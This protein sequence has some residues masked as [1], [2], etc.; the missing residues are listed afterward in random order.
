MSGLLTKVP[1][2][3]HPAPDGLLKEVAPLAQQN[4]TITHK[5]DISSTRW[6]VDTNKPTYRLWL[7]V[8]RQPKIS[9]TTGCGGLVYRPTSITLTTSIIHQ[10]TYSSPA[11]FSSLRQVLRFV[12]LK[13]PPVPYL[14][15]PYPALQHPYNP[16][17]QA[18][19]SLHHITPHQSTT[20]VPLTMSVLFM[21]QKQYR[22]N[23][24]GSRTNAFVQLS[25]LEVEIG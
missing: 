14:T 3:K 22:P 1:C 19:P 6:Y 21:R 10:F 12:I 7:H 8:Q 11:V 15:R 9:R 25:T 20:P 23:C 13:L 18:R 4:H 17:H 24:L 5:K 2:E 16:P